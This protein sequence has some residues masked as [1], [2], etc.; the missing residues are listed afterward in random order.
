MGFSAD[1]GYAENIEMDLLKDQVETVL[2]MSG[3]T[4]TNRMHNGINIL[5][6][7]DSETRDIFYIAFVDNHLVGS[8]TSGLVE[9]AIDSRNNP[10]S[11]ST[12]LLL[13]RRSWFPVRGL[14]E[15]LL[16]MRAYLNSCLFIWGQETNTLICLA[17]L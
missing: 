5:E 12:S 10:K 6:M 1:S 8:Y 2:V 16:I 14:S 11:D 17:I 7:R 9:S 15:S 3:F 13:K 4:V